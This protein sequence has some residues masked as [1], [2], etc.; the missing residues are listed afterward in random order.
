MVANLKTHLLSKGI[1]SNNKRTIVEMSGTEIDQGTETINLGEIE[2]MDVIGIRDLPQ[3]PKAIRKGKVD[4]PEVGLEVDLEIV[5]DHR[6]DEVIK[7][8]MNRNRIVRDQLITDR[9]E[10]RKRGQGTTEI[11]MI[12]RPQIV[13]RITDNSN[14]DQRRE[15][16]IESA[17]RENIDKINLIQRGTIEN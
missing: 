8:G 6:I 1:S 5:I 13:H 4:G 12:V 17:P 9:I 14:M 15:L 7:H 11:G 3:G 2:I 16:M 10:L